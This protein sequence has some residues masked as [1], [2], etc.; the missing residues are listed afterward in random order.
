MALARVSRSTP[1]GALPARFR[2][3]RMHWEPT[4]QR[5]LQRS[6]Q[7]RSSGVFWGAAG[8]TSAGAPKSCAS[9]RSAVCPMPS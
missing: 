7:E 4:E 9:I 8:R 2:P 6:C 5:S 1:V 3:L